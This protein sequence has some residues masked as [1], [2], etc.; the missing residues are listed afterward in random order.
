MRRTERGPPDKA[1][2]L[3][4]HVI[5]T[6]HIPLRRSV[7]LRKLL[8]EIQHYRSY[9]IHLYYQESLQL[10]RETNIQ[11]SINGNIF[12]QRYPCGFTWGKH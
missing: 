10:H 11:E 3:V 12:I 9:S 1:T 2:G 5:I 6:L 7:K 8:N 4:L